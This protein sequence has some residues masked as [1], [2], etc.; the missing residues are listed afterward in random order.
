MAFILIT[1]TLDAIGYGLIMPVMPDLL[2]VVTGGDLA[3]AAQ[4]GGVMT[5]GFAV[6]QFL[7]GP[8]IG[9]LGDRFGRS[10]CCWRRWRRC[11]GIMWCWRWRLRSGWIFGA[12]LLTGVASSTYGTAAAYLA[13]ISTPEQK[14]QRFGLIGAA[15][16]AGFVLGP[17][18]RRVAGAIRSV[19][20]P[21]A[22]LLVVSGANLVFGA[23]ILRELLVPGR[24]RPFDWR[25]ANPFG[26]FRSIGRLR[27][28][29][30]PHDL[31]RL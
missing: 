24:R 21:L 22:A 9:N 15:F 3:R 10:W 6:M 13:D 20:L 28:G 27:A 25:R 29:A 8:V 23:L 17:A 4:W 19:S 11:R 26:A 1:L 16:G 12:R 14:A 5:G 31:H 2:R 18:I 7:F 30:L